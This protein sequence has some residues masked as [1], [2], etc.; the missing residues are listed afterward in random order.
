VRAIDPLSPWGR[1]ALLAGAILI[2]TCALETV[3]HAYVLR[4]GDTAFEVT[5]QPDWGYVVKPVRPAS[6]I[7]AAGSILGTIEGDVRRIG[8]LDPDRGWIVENPDPAGRNESTI[9]RLSRDRDIAYV[10]PLFACEGESLAIIPEI[11]VRVARGT[12]VRQLQDLCRQIGCEVA[13]RMEFTTQEYL[14]R[15]MGPDAEAVFMAVEQFDKV[16]WI[17]WASPNT[18]SYGTPLGQSI[19]QASPSVS[20]D[21]LPTGN[22]GLFGMIPNDPYFPAQWHLHNT[23]QF[24][25]VPDADINALEAWQLTTGD[26]N[27]VIALVDNGVDTSHPDLIDNL[28]PGY[29]FLDND[30]QPRPVMVNEVN[31]HGTM[32]AG[33][34]AAKGNN[35]IGVVGVTWS[36]RVMPVRISM[37]SSATTGVSCSAADRAKAFRWAASHGADI[38]N[39]S[40]KD[41]QNDII[42]SAI[43]DITTA[44]GTGRKGRGCV[45]F[46]S[47]GNEGTR[48][49]TSY[50]CRYPEVIAVGATSPRGVRWN[51]SN[52]GVELDVTTPSASMDSVTY[53]I[54]S[55]SITAGAKLDISSYMAGCNG[56]STACPVAAG[57]AALILS[58]EPDLTS[59]EVRHFLCRSAKDL[60]TPGRDDY[61]GWG[62]VDAQAALDMVLA[63]RADLNDDWSVDEKDL[64]ILTVAM[65]K[66]DRSADIAPAAKRDGIIDAKD[67]ELLIQYLGTKIPE[68]PTPP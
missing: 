55:T 61:Y 5:P 8:G 24:N 7:S 58:L 11:V 18:V 12:H 6:Q 10:A 53:G 54:M 67:R 1:S 28:V 49:P 26:P 62:R 29:D 39:N 44:G 33:L 40:Y 57:V 21:V 59:D 37:A 43:V 27:I 56:T 64:V 51:Y 50:L 16:P 68:M 22:L 45:V 52:Y 20:M 4:A 47:S 14:L 32:C 3:S 17:E 46:F 66:N 34:A 30:D 15:V 23:G 13:E 63:K 19:G 38:L 36:C 9:S 35:G 48:I 41:V 65:E 42:H 60:G 25:Y 31:N 2:T